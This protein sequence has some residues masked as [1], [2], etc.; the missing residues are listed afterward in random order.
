[1]IAHKPV[2]TQLQQGTVDRARETVVLFDGPQNLRGVARTALTGTPDDP[3]EIA[4]VAAGVLAARLQ[5][6]LA[7]VDAITGASDGE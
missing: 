7:V 2:L 5:M 4:A 3:G 1:M 6:L